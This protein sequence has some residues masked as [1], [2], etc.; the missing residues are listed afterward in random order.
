MFKIF[1]DQGEIGNIH[2]KK[3][4]YGQHNIPFQNLNSNKKVCVE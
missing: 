2:K 1:T 3:L 4:S